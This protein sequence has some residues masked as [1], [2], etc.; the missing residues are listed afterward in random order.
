MTVD[1]EALAAGIASTLPDVR[2][3]VVLSAEGLVLGGHPP[4]AVEALTDIWGR[5]AGLGEVARG[6]V[7]VRDQTWVFAR[8]GPYGTVA[9]VGPSGLPGLVLDRLERLL[10][11]AEESRARREVAAPSGAWREPPR[12]ENPRSEPAR[13][14]TGRRGPRSLHPEGRPAGAE[15]TVP[16]VLAVDVEPVAAAANRASSAEVGAKE[17][18]KD[19]A[20]DAKTAADSAPVTDKVEDRALSSPDD[21]EEEEGPE[22]MV[23]EEPDLEVDTFSLAREFSGLFGQEESER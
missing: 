8:R 22:R 23:L 1:F 15:V 2:A 4:G 11:A 6:F 9:V 18:A 17:S 12:I 21:E 14:D 16:D 20:Q 3:C 19:Q 13:T 10:L 5:L 7:T